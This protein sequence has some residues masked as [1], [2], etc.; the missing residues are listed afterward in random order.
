[1]NNYIIHIRVLGNETR[2]DT[3]GA[4]TS[5]TFTDPLPNVQYDFAIQPVNDGGSGPIS[6]YQIGFF[7]RGKLIAYLKS[8]T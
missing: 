6:S 4:E 7:C 8:V 5:W 1:M 2:R 3:R